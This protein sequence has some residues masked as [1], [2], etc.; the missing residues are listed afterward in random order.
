MP[1]AVA[2]IACI[3]LVLISELSRVAVTRMLADTRGARMLAAVVGIVAAYAVV[4][5]LALALYRAE[6]VPTA[7]L[8]VLVDNVP[9]GFPASGKLEPGDRVIALDGAPLTKSLSSLVDERNGAPVRLTVVR[10]SATHEITI[11]PLGHDGHWMLGFR[12]R[13]DHARSHDLGVAARKAIVFPIEQTKQL[14]PARTETVDA[15]G[16][17][18]LAEALVVRREPRP[19]IAA[20]RQSLVFMTYVLLLIAI[21]GIV[22]VVRAVTTR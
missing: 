6:G 8:E 5:A 19:A 1:T 10:G 13:I 22:R 14:V 12:P 15:S 2:I 18:R 21:V 7:N 4:A 16:P 20:L 3:A 11:Q 17:T 9:A